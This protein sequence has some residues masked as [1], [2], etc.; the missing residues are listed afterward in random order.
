M[1]ENIEIRF[2]QTPWNDDY[3]VA[4]FAKDGSGSYVSQPL[5]MRKIKR[6][7]FIEPSAR[8]TKAAMQGLFDQL[9]KAGFRPADGTGNS[10][11]IEAISRHLEDM[12]NLVFRNAKKVN[13]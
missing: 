9:W 2:H 5:E 13:P 12:R 1:K 11:H 4:F 10:G 6:G 3:E 7:E 8:L